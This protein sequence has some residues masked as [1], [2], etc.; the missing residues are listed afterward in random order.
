MKAKFLTDKDILN[1]N[2]YYGLSL[3]YLICILKKTKI[4]LISML[5]Y[6]ILFWH[7]NWSKINY[8]PLSDRKDLNEMII[9]NSFFVFCLCSMILMFRDMR[10]FFSIMT[11]TIII[12]LLVLNYK[13]QLMFAGSLYI[14]SLSINEL[15]FNV[16][17]CIYI[18]CFISVIIGYFFDNNIWLKCALVFLNDFCLICFSILI[19]HNSLN[20]TD[21]NRFS[22]NLYIYT[23]FFSLGLLILMVIF[24]EL[25]FA[26]SVILITMYCSLIYGIT[27]LVDL[28]IKNNYIIV[29]I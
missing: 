11:L 15:L 7:V 9:L 13:H 23:F 24:K 27:S 5:I 19:K 17:V 28:M 12:L 8:T 3:F 1:I 25:K 18:F 10:F 21:P 14:A 16:G 6:S 22:F 2:I 20:E 26:T 4:T 29:Q